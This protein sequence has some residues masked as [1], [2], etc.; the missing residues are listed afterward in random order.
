[1]VFA[2]RVLLSGDQNWMG[3]IGFTS[4]RAPHE[5]LQRAGHQNPW[6][7]FGYMSVGPAQPLGSLLSRTPA[8]QG[9]KHS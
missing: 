6:A 8:G 1:V 3:L 5:M 7:D 9:P 4:P 2:F